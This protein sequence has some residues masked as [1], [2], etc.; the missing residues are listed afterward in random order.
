[1]ITV[2]IEINGRLIQEINAH[3][4][5]KPMDIKDPN[6]RE[7]CIH[8]GISPNGKHVYHRRNDGSTKLAIK[9]LESIPELLELEDHE[10]DY[11]NLE[12]ALAELCH[13]Q[14][15]GWMKYLFS[16]CGEQVKFE[17]GEHFKTGN[18]VIPK[19][20]VERWGR[21]MTTDYDF[22]SAEEQESDRVE[23]RK[24]IKLIQSGRLS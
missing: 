17:E 1:M 12:E 23:A 14:W 11:K 7:Y 16:H 19:W 18:M 10:I 4:V 9:M 22:L 15:S 2:K 5:G 21:Q 8:H 3:N 24:F 13:S 20:A 6:V